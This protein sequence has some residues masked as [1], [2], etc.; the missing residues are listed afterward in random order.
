MFDL[1]K[2][3]EQALRDTNEALIR[4]GEQP[5][6]ERLQVFYDTFR[7]RFGPG[8]LKSLDGEALLETMHG[9]GKNS[10]AYW[11]EFKNDEEF[12]GRLFGSISGGSAH[13]FGVFR[14]TDTLQWV[15][16]SSQNA[17]TIS[18]GEAASIARRHRD[19]LVAGWDLLD[20]FSSHSSDA[21]YQQLQTQLTQVMPDL[22]A[23]AWAHKYL[24]LLFPDKLDNYHSQH[25][26]RFHLIKLL[27]LPPALPGLYVCAGRFV[28]LASYFG[29]NLN[30]L[31]RVLNQQNGRP[32]KYW[33]MGTWVK[34]Q[35]IWEEMRKGSYVA[36]GW[37]EVGDLT[38]FLEATDLKEV[39]RQKLESKYQG[40]PGS[41]SKMAGEI[42]NFATE[43]KP[44]ELVVAGADENILGIGRII[45]PYRFETTFPDEAPHRREV[46]W[47][48]I[49]KWKQPSPEGKMTKVFPLSKPEN[50][51]EIER[52]CLT[53]QPNHLAEV[54]TQTVTHHSLHLEGIPARIQSILERKGQAILFGPPGTGKTYWARKTANDLAAWGTFGRVF[55]DLTL[56][57][58]AQIPGTPHEPG[59]VWHCTFHPAYGYEDFLEGYR[60][61]E[62]SGQLVFQLR[63]GIFK[64]ICTAARRAPGQKF[65]L[66]IDE[67]NRGDIPRIFG[68]LL[69]L[70]ELDKRG[71]EIQL[72]LSG[73]S[74][75]VPPNIFVIGTMNTA[76]R[77]IALLDTALRRRFG[78]EELMP[79][80][81][82]F[83]DAVVEQSIPLGPWLNALNHRICAGLGRDARNLQIGHAYFLESGKPV[84]DFGRFSRIL[85]NDII[86]LLEEYCYQDY[87]GLARILGD[88]LVDKTRQ[89][90]RKELFGL[91]QREELIQELLAPTPE[92]TTTFKATLNS[93][94]EESEE[95]LEG[96][97]DPS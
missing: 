29:W 36:I 39:V 86:P 73:E 92:I 34:D 1:D 90:I 96:K 75:S 17:T 4:K 70:L 44:G 77:S 14:R 74:F 12:G 5:P 61:Q 8:K 48:S 72:A 11:L 60:P 21:A 88:G 65:Y 6:L 89:R 30:H 13:K 94:G 47:L 33:R 97:E 43:I 32:V 76:D 55:A 41:L 7:D 20:Q 45:G 78:F 10:L 91:N 54:K 66:I 51:L 27:Q 57:E 23:S 50:V 67:I 9:N 46:E 69:T 68:E 80:M 81:T 24:S 40:A 2:N 22:F 83:G 19:Q 52:R 58:K 71:T 56:E 15:K 26:Q 53:V 64:R 28:Q 79:D 84:T 82:V 49:E 93:L 38:P 87:T 42:R 16:G 3:L 31:T 18:V 63:D 62:K 37:K 85:E 35:S 95:G 25:Y 59:L